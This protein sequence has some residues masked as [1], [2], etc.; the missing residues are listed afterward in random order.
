ML[1]QHNLLILLLIECCVP[2]AAVLIVCILD[3]VGN[4]VRSKPFGLDYLYHISPNM[5]NI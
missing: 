3:F 2:A 1:Y 5:I 4:F